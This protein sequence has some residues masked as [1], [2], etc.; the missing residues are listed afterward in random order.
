M[1]PSSKR[2]LHAGHSKHARHT[3]VHAS[4]SCHCRQTSHSSST[5]ESTDKA[6]SNSPL[7]TPACVRETQARW[8][9]AHI[10]PM[11]RR[12]PY[13]YYYRL[14][15]LK[16]GRFR[17]AHAPPSQ[18]LKRYV[19]LKYTSTYYYCCCCCRCQTRLSWWWAMVA[20]LRGWIQSRNKA[21]SRQ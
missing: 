19:Y 21:Q 8:Q 18:K 14:W 1:S 11:Q 5:R 20:K 13:Y 7:Q 6:G 10:D 17:K 16:T 4:V 3:L 15:E 2:W 12:A 9:K